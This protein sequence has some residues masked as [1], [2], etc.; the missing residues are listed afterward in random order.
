MLFLLIFDMKI[1]CNGALETIYN[2]FLVV[3]CNIDLIMTISSSSDILSSKFLNFT[4]RTRGDPQGNRRGKSLRGNQIEISFITIMV[5]L[6]SKF[7][8]ND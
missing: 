7:T 5:K 8:R 3:T 6:N 2:F 4:I 1:V